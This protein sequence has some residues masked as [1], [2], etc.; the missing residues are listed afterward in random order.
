MEHEQPQ[1]SLYLPHEGLSADT[2]VS[3]GRL[4]CPAGG[5]GAPRTDNACKAAALKL[6]FAVEEAQKLQVGAGP[7]VHDRVQQSHASWLS[8]STLDLL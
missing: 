4:G 6:E 8:E 7:G 3:F 1:L 2:L 5:I